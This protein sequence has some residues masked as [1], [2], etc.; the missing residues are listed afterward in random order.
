MSQEDQATQIGKLVLRRNELIQKQ[1][2]LRAKASEFSKAHMQ[3][4]T[5]IAEAAK[6]GSGV[7]AALSEIPTAENVSATLSELLRTQEELA[8]TKSQLTPFGI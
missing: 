6:G 2:A 1:A 8:S 5:A 7:E 3:L 4:A